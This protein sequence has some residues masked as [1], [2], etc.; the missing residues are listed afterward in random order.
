VTTSTPAALAVPGQRRPEVPALQ[1]AI[2][3][4]MDHVD[5][6]G[7]QGRVIVMDLGLAKDLLDLIEDMCVAHRR[8]ASCDDA[9]ACL[10][11]GIGDL[12]TIDDWCLHFGLCPSCRAKGCPDC[13]AGVA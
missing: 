6:R 10:A 4:A 9:V 8:C 13:R 11:C 12:T 5:A 2:D 1:A 3:T 7:H